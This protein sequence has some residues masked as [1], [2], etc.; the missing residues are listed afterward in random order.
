MNRQAEIIPAILVESGQEAR[1]KVDTISPYIRW[2][3]LDVCDGTFVD[4]VSWGDPQGVR[5][6]IQNV[7]VEIH[8][9]VQNPEHSI[10]GWLESGAKRIYIHYEST[11]KHKE[12][13]EKI[14]N[15]GIEAGIALLPE[16]STDV[17][18][19]LYQY[20]DCVLVFSGN[21]G[22]YGGEFLQ[23]PTFTKLSILQKNYKDIII[24][25]DGGVNP[26]VARMVHER[27]VTHIVSG[28]YIFNSNSPKNRIQ[29]LK[30]AVL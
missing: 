25:V 20:I 27:G 9:M 4:R 10:D 22:H 26:D 17:I 8:L 3:Q 16:T 19:D 29:D 12:V 2:V 1:E 6:C 11:E 18:H 23:E 14:K 5:E 28:G 30:Q 7:F 15:A 13:L 24:E 21:L